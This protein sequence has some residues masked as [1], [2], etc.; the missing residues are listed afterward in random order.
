MNDAANAKL[1]HTLT[2]FLGSET[3]QRES[4]IVE[5]V[6]APLV[7]AMPKRGFSGGLEGSI[8]VKR[9]DPKTHKAMNRV[10][11]RLAKLT[12]ETPARLEYAEAFVLDVSPEELREIASWPEVAFVRPNR[13]HRA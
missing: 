13:V 2:D 1:D 5:I 7:R 8:R 4:V 9:P 10:G 3:K 6:S 12:A 11:D